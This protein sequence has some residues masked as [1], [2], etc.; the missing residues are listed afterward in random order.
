M[1]RTKESTCPYC[2]YKIDAISG[3]DNEKDMPK[4]G[5]VSICIKC[6]GFM[7]F[8]E[9]C[10]LVE[11]KQEEFHEL[12]DQVKKQLAKLRDCILEIRENEFEP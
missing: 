2:G 6:A 8:T 4:K 5:D 10:S 3:I 1:P 12:P 9:D 7:T 11:M